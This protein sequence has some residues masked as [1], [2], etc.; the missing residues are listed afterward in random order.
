[1]MSD[2]SISDTVTRLLHAVDDL[3]RNTAR[4]LLAD[5]VAPDY[6]SLWGGEP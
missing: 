5:R 1:M 4:A 6:T 3:D 2:Q